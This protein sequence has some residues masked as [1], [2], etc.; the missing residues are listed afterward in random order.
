MINQWNIPMKY[1]YT[2]YYHQ[3]SIVISGGNR[4]SSKS[5]KIIDIIWWAIE[6]FRQVKPELCGTS[7][8][9]YF[10]NYRLENNNFEDPHI[11]NQISN[12]SCIHSVLS[13]MNIFYSSWWDWWN[14]CNSFPCY[15]HFLS[16]SERVF[17]VFLH[18]AYIPCNEAVGITIIRSL[19][20]PVTLHKTPL[21]NSFV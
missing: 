4:S 14:Q 6:W 16:K 3:L 19:I 17:I 11:W 9:S 21:N 12:T 7:S 8:P 20:S 18:Y 2:N 5:R 15:Y 10:I 13:L 1:K